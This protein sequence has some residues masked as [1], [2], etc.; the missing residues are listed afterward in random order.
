VIKN[1]QD[2]ILRIESYIS[3]SELKPELR[4]ILEQCISRLEN[5]IEIYC[6]EC[7]ETFHAPECPCYINKSEHPLLKPFLRTD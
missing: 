7:G 5:W 2:L 1:N 6:G 4:S 3:C